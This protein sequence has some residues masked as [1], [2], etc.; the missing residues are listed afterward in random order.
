VINPLDYADLSEITP[1][2]PLKIARPLV[3]AAFRFGDYSKIEGVFVPW[4]SGQAFAD[5]GRWEPAQVKELKVMAA[6][7]A[8]QFGVLSI[9]LIDADTTTLSYFQAGARFST[10]VSH[11]DIGIQYYTG[12]LPRPAYSVEMASPPAITLDYNRYHQIGLDYAAEAAGFNIRAEAAVNMTGDLSGDDPSV[13]NPHVLWSLGFDRSLF[14]GINLN[15]QCNERIRLFDDEVGKEPTDI[16]KDASLTSTRITAEISRAFFRDT[17]RLS[18]AAIWGVEDKD[19]FIIPAVT[20]TRGSA[21]LELSGGFFLGDRDGELGQYRDN[22][23][24]KTVMKYVF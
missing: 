2:E 9:D 12:F 7:I 15:L 11:S 5:E 4:F 13:Y 22:S 18:T 1:G 19:V 17:V 21:E 24:V 16:E 3:H 14:A 8:A 10:T 20:F 6:Q 23:F